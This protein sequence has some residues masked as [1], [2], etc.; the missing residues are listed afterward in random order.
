MW[1]VYLIQCNDGSFYTGVTSNLERRFNEHKTGS[2]SFHTKL[3]K[4][5]KILYTEEYHNKLEAIKRE[6]K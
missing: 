5:I 3:H 2:G 4:P 1:Y 6:K